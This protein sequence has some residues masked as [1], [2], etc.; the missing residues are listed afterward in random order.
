MTAKLASVYGA[1]P[2]PPPPPLAP[3]A[4]AGARSV[5]IFPEKERERER[6]RKEKKKNKKFGLAGFFPFSA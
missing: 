4:K 3:P 2:P 1:P 5:R 6:K